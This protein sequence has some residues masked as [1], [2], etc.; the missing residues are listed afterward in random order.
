MTWTLDIIVALIIG[1]TVYFAAKNGFVK[2]AI[3]AVSFIIAIAVTAALAGPLAEIIKETPVANTVEAATEEQITNILLE[4]SHSIDELIDGKS[5]EFNTFIA[6][7][8]LEKAELSE[9]YSDNAEND[10]KAESVIAQKIAEPIIDTVA[11]LVAILVLY[12]G[13]Q[14]VLS[15]L[16]FFLDK[17]ARLPVLKSCNKL[18]GIILGA[19]LAVVRV[20]L[21]C[22]VVEILIENSAFLGSDMLAGL[23]PENTLL[24]KFFSEIDIFSFFI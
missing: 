21:F 2:T 4:G 19:A 17:I 11:L 10:K 6:I 18:L 8:G 14:I 13:S 7:A 9:W 1:L 23:K 22:F 16:T 12:I 3:S 5:E 15:V 24:Y 20:C